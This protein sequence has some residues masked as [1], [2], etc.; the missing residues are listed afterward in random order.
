MSND[1]IS[2]HGGA[3]NTAVQ[4]Y[5]QKVN[6]FETASQAIN[7]AAIDLMNTWH[8]KG[9][10]AFDDAVHKW[11]HD[12]KT[13]SADLQAIADTMTKSLNAMTDTDTQI[14]NAFKGFN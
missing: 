10:Q 11:Q 8:G 13:I 6:D 4:N 5:T 7:N 3:L 14:A 9:S 2:I 1:Q 12:M